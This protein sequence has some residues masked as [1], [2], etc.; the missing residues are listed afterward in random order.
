MSG[1]QQLFN[2]VC[3]ASVY[4]LV[5]VGYNVV[6][7][8]MRIINLAHC[9]ILMAGAYAGYFFFCHVSQNLFLCI[10]FAALFSGLLG[11]LLEYCIYRPV[12]DA[13]ANVTLIVATGASLFLQY[14]V[15][16]IF[17]AAPRGAYFAPTS[18]VIQFW[19]I[20]LPVSKLI[21]LACALLLLIAL[22]IFLKKTR[23]GMAMRAV[24]SNKRFA[25]LTG[26]RPNS[27][28]SLS[29]FIGS[30]LAGVCGVLL[31]SQFS[32]APFMGQSFG[33]KAFC[34]AVIGGVGSMSG[35]LLGA[36][37]LAFAETFFGTFLNSGLKDI[38]GFFCLV[39]VILFFPRGLSR[40]GEEQKR[41]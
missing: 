6:F 38:L 21:T 33:L 34:A 32:I 30:A 22:E 2:A 27:I 39:V 35:A 13:G 23:T 9:D 11:S 41:V 20:T 29:F 7:G 37:F 25:A 15:I 24:S 19:G 18:A 1:L 8:V 3:L 26:I 36:F 28:I 17:G 14:A 5:A 16:L 4:A 40:Q 31:L 12:A 10:I